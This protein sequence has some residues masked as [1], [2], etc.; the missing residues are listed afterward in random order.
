MRKRQ[1]WFLVMVVSLLLWVGNVFGGWAQAASEE[2]QPQ[3]PMVVK[4]LLVPES[5]VSDTPKSQPNTARVVFTGL[6]GTADGKKALLDTGSSPREGTSSAAWY[7]EGDS[8]GPYILKEI[9]TNTIVLEGAGETLRLP[10]Y[11]PDKD[12]PEPLELAAGPLDKGQMPQKGAPEGTGQEQ[13]QGQ[14]QPAS[15]FGPSP[16][17]VTP[18]KGAT[19]PGQAQPQA[20]G[21]GSNPFQEAIE[22]AR[23]RQ[24]SGQGTGQ[25]PFPSP[26]G[27]KS[28]SNPFMDMIKKQQQQ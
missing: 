3:P 4:H 18:D 14:G 13:A 26:Q 16:K 19:P 17:A 5:H 24:G 15:P 23:Q 6:M 22:K 25:G 1:G 9:G 2:S 8:V 7:R 21:G 20:Q 28:G 11:G 12:R 27:S 10:L